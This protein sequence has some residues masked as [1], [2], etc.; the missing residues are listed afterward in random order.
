MWFKS[1]PISNITDQLISGNFTTKYIKA[2]NAVKLMLNIVHL[3]KTEA[4][5]ADDVY[6]KIKSWSEYILRIHSKSTKHLDRSKMAAL[7]DAMSVSL[8]FMRTSEIIY[9]ILEG[10]KLMTDGVTFCQKYMEAFAPY[11][12]NSRILSDEKIEPYLSEF[13]L[14]L[15]RHYSNKKSDDCANVRI[16]DLVNQVSYFDFKIL[17]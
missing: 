4:I 8:F 15:I 6:E 12:L 1:L 3:D 9:L 7:V 11:L 13:L 5:F 10:Q 17:L 2:I 16:F 14:Q